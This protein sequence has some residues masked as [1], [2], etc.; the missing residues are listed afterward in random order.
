MNWL[1]I[2]AIV[3]LTGITGTGAWLDV[4]FRQLPNGL[5]LTAL[6]AGLT[7]V[8]V[9]SDAP[10]MGMAFLHFCLALAIGMALFSVKAIGGGDAKYYA[11]LAAW[12]PLS[13]GVILIG[14]VSIA[15]LV[16][17]MV[18]LPLRIMHPRKN[19]NPQTEDL[20]AKLPYGV[21]ISAGALA[22]F[23]LRLA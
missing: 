19:L 17:L 9:S 12:F 10:A 16:L 8:L 13:D 21:A 18:W 20:F 14:A 15:G 2:G 5:C 1:Q 6:V 23:A 3:V 22:A 7:F 11:A 4:R